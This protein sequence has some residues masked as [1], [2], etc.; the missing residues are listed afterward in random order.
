MSPTAK[1][2]L[3][4]VCRASGCVTDSTDSP[5]QGRRALEK[6]SKRML[7]FKGLTVIDVYTYCKYNIFV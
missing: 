3:G 4:K 6:W 5:R 2:K 7:K 1:T